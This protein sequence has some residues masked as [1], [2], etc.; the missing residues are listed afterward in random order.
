MAIPID[1]NNALE[2]QLNQIINMQNINEKAKSI[3][4]RYRKNDNDGKRLLTESDEA[5]AYALS[6]MPATYEA[7]YS[8]INKTFENNNFNINTVFDIGAGT[9]SATWAITELLNNSPNITCFEREDAMIKV[10]KNLISYSEK[11]KKTEWKKFDIIKDEINQTADFVMVSYMINELPKSE[12]N[13]IISKLWK[14]TNKILFVIEPGTPRGFSNIKQIRSQLLQ[15]NAHIIAPCPHENECTLP[16]DDWC[17]FTA[18]VQRSKIHKLFKDGQLSYEDEKFSYIAF[19]KQTVNIA[20]N[21]I[22]RHPIINKGYTEFKICTKL[23]IQNMK[24]S[25]KDGYKY[26]KSKKKNAGDCI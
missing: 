21:R 25:K 13:K 20:D 7:D 17:Q 9:G 2:N 16:Q 19:S 11:L 1:L 6:R 18:R 22:L 14:A 5:V 15:E 26:K 10:G 8:A 24:L 3:S 12:V 23:G 4:E